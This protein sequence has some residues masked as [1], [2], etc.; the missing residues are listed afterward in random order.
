MVRTWSYPGLRHKDGSFE[1]LKTRPNLVLAGMEGAPYKKY[2]ITFQPGDEI[3]LY[4]DGVPE[5]KNK[6]NE[7]FGMD[8]LVDALNSSAETSPWNVL[9]AVHDAV[10]A[11]TGEEAQFDDLTMMCL[12]YNG[13]N[14]NKTEEQA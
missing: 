2:E 7:Q 9:A 4:T 13:P 6:A 1:F 3:F 14:G 12:I 10:N 8:R 11:F 5:A